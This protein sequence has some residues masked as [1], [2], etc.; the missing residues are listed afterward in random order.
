MTRDPLRLPIIDEEHRTIHRELA[1]LMNA[2][3][4]GFSFDDVLKIVNDAFR[5]TRRHFKHEESI[6]KK[7][8]FEKLEQHRREHSKIAG[9]L[10]KVLSLLG[11]GEPAAAF[12]LIREFR[13][14]L[15][16]HLQNSDEQ[17]RDAVNRY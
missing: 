1:N 10:N 7:I 8:G 12:V 5:V 14:A 3:T 13:K 4:L 17:Y 6:L 2:I 9:M 16:L 15:L 11:G